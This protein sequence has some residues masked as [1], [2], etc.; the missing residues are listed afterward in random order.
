MVEQRVKREKQKH[1]VRV[2]AM[3]VAQNVIE[4]RHKL[5]KAL[6]HFVAEDDRVALAQVDAR[7]CT[8]ASSTPSM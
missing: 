1:V 8:S 3:P 4:R 5:A 7:G 6:L 2:P